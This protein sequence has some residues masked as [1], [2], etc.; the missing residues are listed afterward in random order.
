MAEDLLPPAH[1]NQPI[2]LLVE[3]SEEEPRTIAVKAGDT[4]GRDASNS[5]VLGDS[6]ASKHHARI[7]ESEGLLAIE[8]LGSTNGIWVGSQ[9]LTAERPHPLLHGDRL[10]IGDATLRVDAPSQPRS[11]DGASGAGAAEMDVTVAPANAASSL[12]NTVAPTAGGSA[13]SSKQA[14]EDMTVQPGSHDV[15]IPPQPVQSSRPAPRPPA[16]ATPSPK[17]K[18]AARVTPAPPASTKPRPEPI[19]R[20][21]SVAVP[22][23]AQDD[24]LAERTWMWAAE[25][26][27]GDADASSY[28]KA[29]DVRLVFVVHREPRTERLTKPTTVVGRRPKDGID[30]ALGDDSVSGIHAKISLNQS[31]FRVQDLDSSN[32][33][34]VAGS[35]LASGGETKGVE[36]DTRISFGAVD[37]FLVIPPRSGATDEIK[38]EKKI[39]QEALRRLSTDVPAA[40]AVISAVEKGLEGGTHPGEHLVHSGA[41]SVAQWTDAMRKARTWHEM[42]PARSNRGFPILLTALIVIAAAAAAA[43]YALKQTGS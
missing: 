26:A 31:T 27:L 14:L 15:T 12:E 7:V 11:N 10:T 40:K 34:S 22:P 6:K 4:I 30:I 38:A 36:S 1:L 23:P 20:L 35:W 21:D 9:R 8:D 25:P 16:E 5:I 29:V 2:Q 13:P 3:E 42:Q 41:I 37:A 33:V 24:S 19:P 17:A 32:G 39:H 28:L 43:V 18:P